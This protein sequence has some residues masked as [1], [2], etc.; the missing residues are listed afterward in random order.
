MKSLHDLLAWLRAAPEGTMISASAAIGLLEA[1]PMPPE[2]VQCTH[3]EPGESPWSAMLWLAPAE[4]RLGVPE[5][6]EAT[7]RSKSWLYRHTGRNGGCSRIPHRKMD[8]ELVFLAGEV[9]EW[10][11]THEEIVV[12]SRVLRSKM[13]SRC[14]KRA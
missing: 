8:G 4:T 9:R 3:S 6:L 13:A 5:L 1:L 2:P 10:L 7:G 12:P 11:Q 14:K